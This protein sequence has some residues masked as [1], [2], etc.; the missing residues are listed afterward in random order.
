MRER[1]ELAAHTLARKGASVSEFVLGSQFDAAM[2]DHAV[3]ID[4][5]AARAL[6]FE[7]QN[8]YDKLSSSLLENIENGWRYSREQYDAALAS[9]VEY[10]AAITRSFQDYDF[11]L[12]PSAPGEA[13]EGLASTGNSLFNRLWT[14]FGTPCVTVPA[15]IGPKGLPIGVQIVG[16][17]GADTQTLYWADWV[18]RAL[19]DET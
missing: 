8:H 16:R 5:E 18:R 6:A 7:Y 1:L 17:Y 14:L 3:I 13:P 12:T 19:S 10:R 11:L 2:D 4:F 9:A 15:Y